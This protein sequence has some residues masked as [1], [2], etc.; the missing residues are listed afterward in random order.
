MRSRRD[1]STRFG[2]IDAD[3]LIYG[4]V[5]TF[6]GEQNMHPIGN[7]LCRQQPGI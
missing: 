4:E 1:G 7:P 5:V 2:H 6:R 3:G